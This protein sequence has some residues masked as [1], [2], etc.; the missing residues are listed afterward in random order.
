MAGDDP[1][2][3]YLNDHM[4]GATLGLDLAKRIAEAAGNSPSGAAMA[5]IAADIEAD[6]NLL[7]DLIARL[8]YQ[9]HNIKQAAAW[10]A[11]KLSRL[12]LNRAVVGSADL[13]RLMEMETLSMG[14]QGKRNL[15]ETL[16]MVAGSD[17]NLSSLDFDTL[18]AR[19][20]DQQNRL[21]A[22]RRLMAAPA[23]RATPE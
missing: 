7:E 9:E 20:D 17:P 16:R 5:E 2:G 23:L 22:Q 13:A 8:G 6:R 4:A 15:W 10:M 14:V 21:S 1:L 3:L 12:R 19:A 18:I 11:E